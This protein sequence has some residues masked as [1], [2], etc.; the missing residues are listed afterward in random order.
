MYM[1]KTQQF[2]GTGVVL[3]AAI[4]GDGLVGYWSFDEGV[5]TVAYDRSGNENTGTLS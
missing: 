1:N 3:K 4:A 5:G 2:S